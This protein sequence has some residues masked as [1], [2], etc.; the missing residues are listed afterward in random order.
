MLSFLQTTFIQIIQHVISTS[1]CQFFGFIGDF[2]PNYLLSFKKKI[3]LLLAKST[4][5]VNNKILAT[6]KF[7]R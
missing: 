7:I 4:H 5:I 1:A 3:Q 6:L 2:L